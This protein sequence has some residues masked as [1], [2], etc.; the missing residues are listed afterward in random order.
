MLLK[1][2]LYDVYNTVQTPTISQAEHD[3]KNMYLYQKV[4]KVLGLGLGLHSYGAQ[5]M[6]VI[7]FHLTTSTPLTNVWNITVH[8][9]LS[10]K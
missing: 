7:T 6:H 1:S 9:Y 8:N 2:R 3:K 5:V 4:Y 10:L